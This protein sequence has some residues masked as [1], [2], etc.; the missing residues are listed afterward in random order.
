MTFEQHLSECLRGYRDALHGR[1]PSIVYTASYM[2]GYKNRLA[3]RDGRSR[4][5]ADQIREWAD[6]AW[7]HDAAAFQF[8]VIGDG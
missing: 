7:R 2:H 3:D 6:K 1:P 8:S 4:G 5:T